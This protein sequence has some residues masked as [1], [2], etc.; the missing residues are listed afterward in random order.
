VH[1][2]FIVGKNGHASLKGL[3]LIRHSACRGLMAS[4]SAGRALR[5]ESSR[6][7]VEHR[8]PDRHRP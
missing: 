4:R 8:K 1:D 2:H 3:R 6:V 5:K 7:A